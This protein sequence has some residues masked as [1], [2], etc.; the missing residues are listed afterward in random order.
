MLLSSLLLSLGLYHVVFIKVSIN[1]SWIQ[2]A[3]IPAL[4][5]L[6]N[7]TFDSMYRDLTSYSFLFLPC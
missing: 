4:I 7:F 2:L 5:H 3:I 1:A 6:V